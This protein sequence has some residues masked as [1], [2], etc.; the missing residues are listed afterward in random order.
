[1][2]ICFK[3]DR[4]DKYAH[5][6]SKVNSFAN[7]EYQPRKIKVIPKRQMRPKVRLVN[8][9]IRLIQILRIPMDD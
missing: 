6:S 1:M 5:I 8:R 2:C 9:K 7:F 3:H 4:H